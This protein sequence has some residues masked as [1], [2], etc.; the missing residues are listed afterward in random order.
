MAHRRCTS[1]RPTL[2]AAGSDCS[3]GQACVAAGHADDGRF[4]ELELESSLPLGRAGE[5]HVREGVVAELVTVLDELANEA[6]LPRD[7]A[8][9]DE[10][11]G[12]DVRCTQH[13]RDLRRPARVGPV[14]ERQRDASPGRRLL[15]DELAPDGCQDRPGSG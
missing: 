3:S 8:A 6:G 2:F 11:R 10:E 9:D 14:V 13:R 1:V 15:G 4:G 7:L 5:I 12:G